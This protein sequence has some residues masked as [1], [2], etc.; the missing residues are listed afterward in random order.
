M[1]DE[2]VFCEIQAHEIKRQFNRF[3]M[4]LNVMSL[5]GMF[6]NVLFAI[7][8]KFLTQQLAPVQSTFVLSKRVEATSTL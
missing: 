2:I 7:I 1:T 4:F 5:N 3:W 6:F 8:P